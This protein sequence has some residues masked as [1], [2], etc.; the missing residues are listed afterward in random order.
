M[1]LPVLLGV[2]PGTFGSAPVS[3]IHRI[4]AIGPA[5]TLARTPGKGGQC[6]QM[7]VSVRHRP[8]VTARPEGV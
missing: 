4:S 5:Q 7:T 3:A 2:Q 8:H 1:I 6:P